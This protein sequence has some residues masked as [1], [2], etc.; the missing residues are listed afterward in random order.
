MLSGGRLLA[1]GGDRQ[2]REPVRGAWLP[3][4]L[5]QGDSLPRLGAG[6]PQLTRQVMST[7]RIVYAVYCYLLLL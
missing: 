6:Q 2:L 4:G 5:H 7:I 1:A 3:R